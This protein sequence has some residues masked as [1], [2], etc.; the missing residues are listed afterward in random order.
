MKQIFILSLFVTILTSCESRL[1]IR[2]AVNI[3]YDYY[4][5]V[6]GITDGD[7]FKGLTQDKI[8]IRFRIYGIDAPENKQAFSD[9]SKQYLSDLIYGKRVGIVVQKKSDGYGRPVVWVYTPEN[10]DVSA[11]MLKA[12]MAWHYKQ[13]DKSAK[14]SELESEAR[15]H[16]IG[17]WSDNN[18]IAPWDFRK[19]K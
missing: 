13:Y 3:Q 7:T 8:E 1:G 18:P 10:K 16:K 9:K 17:L 15:N 5:Q 6:V 4:I 2:N 14:Y 19:K 11:E 12:G